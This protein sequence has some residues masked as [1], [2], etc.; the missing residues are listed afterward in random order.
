MSS[1][2]VG[3]VGYGFSGSTFHAPVLSAVEAL[4]LAAV[5][6]SKPGKVSADWPGVRVF[7]RIEDLLATTDIN[8]VVITSPNTLHYSHAKAALEAGKHVVVEK[9]FTITSREAD[10]LIELAEQRSLL[11]SVYQNRRWD[12][13]FLTVQRVVKSGLL[14]VIHSYEAHFDRYQP[15]VR[16]RWRE[17]DLPGSGI[18]YDLGAHL[19]DQALVLFGAP[20]TVFADLRKQRPAAKAVDSFHLVLGYENCRVVLSAGNLVKAQGPRFQLYGDLGSFVK[21]GTDPQEEALRAGGRPGDL[22]W[23]VDCPEHYGVLTTEVA[24]LSIA[25]AI[26]TE[27]GCYQ[28]YYRG[29]AEAILNNQPPPVPAAQARAT[30]RIL[31]LAE[32]SHQTGRRMNW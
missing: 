27:V 10:S 4:T 13:D 16:E 3:L 31:E 24:G 11:L 17:Q 9:P 32:Q 23:G 20:Q 5:T 8:L 6:T 26:P 2:S 7:G 29:L 12:N 21:S 14:G 1:L 28:A 30:I 18:L 19:I 25:T 15:L 22:N